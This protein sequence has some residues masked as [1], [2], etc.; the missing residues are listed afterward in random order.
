MSGLCWFVASLG[1]VILIL[2]GLWFFFVYLVR[3][4]GRIRVAGPMEAVAKGTANPLIELIDKF[5]A[6]LEKLTDRIEKKYLPGVFMC[7]V[8]AVILGLTLYL[9]LRS[10]NHEKKTATTSGTTSTTHKKQP[11]H[12]A[13][14]AGHC[15]VP[16]VTRRRLANARVRIRRA[17]CSV[18]RVRYV[19]SRE[20]PGYVIRQRPRAGRI[21]HAR[22]KV[23]MVVSRGRR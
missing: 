7:V 15:R 12:P 23:N 19:L 6:W 8:G 17:H 4:V 5:F 22:A 10:G 3:P 18:G 16:K 14:A 20:R 13:H 11:P 21:R 1:A 9:C 2:G